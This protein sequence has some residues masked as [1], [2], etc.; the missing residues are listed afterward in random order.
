MSWFRRNEIDDLDSDVIER[1]A[2]R[3]ANDFA[4]LTGKYDERTEEII[5]LLREKGSQLWDCKKYYDMA[6]EFKEENKTL[7]Q[8]KSEKQQEINAL[9]KQFG[10]LGEYFITNQVP[11][12][13]QAITS[14]DELITYLKIVQ[15]TD[16]NL[17][18]MRNIISA[19]KR[20]KV[21][22]EDMETNHNDLYVNLKIKDWEV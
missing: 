2:R 4:D 15:Y 22:K 5:E 11:S 13:P 14:H 12:K 18:P 3:I 7:K 6:L 8:E 9:K 1:K 17:L 20:L 16:K 10:E 21:S 19:M